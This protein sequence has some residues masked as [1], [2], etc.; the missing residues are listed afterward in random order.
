MEITLY[1]TNSEI[2]RLDK[3]LSN[4]TVI[5]GSLKSECSIINPKIIIQ[6]LNP[7]QFN[8]CYIPSFNRYYYISNITSIR[9]N[10]WLIECSV[11]VLMSF[12]TQIKNMSVIVAEDSTDDNE[13]Y[14]NGKPWQTTVKTK[15]DVIMFP[16]GLLESGEYILITS[17][18]VAS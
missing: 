17:G 15:T 13:T 11:D 4:A 6:Y 16:S 14:I 9:T 18:G 12:N 5:S 2:E 7:S 3:T 1:V 8:Y 10:L